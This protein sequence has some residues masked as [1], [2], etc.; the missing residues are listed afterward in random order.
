MIRMLNRSFRC[1]VSY[2]IVQQSK[3]TEEE[4][5]KKRC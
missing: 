4:T 3:K 5:K 1:A 2:L